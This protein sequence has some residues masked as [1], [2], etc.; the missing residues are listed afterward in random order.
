MV[1]RCA[2][3]TK[4]ADKMVVVCYSS[5]R[6]L[7][8]FPRSLSPTLQKLQSSRGY[9]SRIHI[10]K[11]KDLYAVLGVPPSATQKQVKEAYYALS[12]KYHPDKNKGSDDAH[13]MF[14][15]LTEAYSVLGQYESRKKYDKGLLQDFPHQRSHPAS[16]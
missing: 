11:P 9:S 15:S 1:T 10:E 14:T 16:T 2:T 7:F 4:C 6:G 12:M 13:Y 5:L 8:L 3:N